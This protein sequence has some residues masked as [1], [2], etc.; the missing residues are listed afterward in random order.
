MSG[1]KVGW[2]FV[3]CREEEQELGERE[4]KGECLTVLLAVGADV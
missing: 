1:R 4:G 3:V 2:L